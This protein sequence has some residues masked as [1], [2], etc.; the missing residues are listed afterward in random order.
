MFLTGKNYYLLKVIPLPTYKMLMF[1]FVLFSAKVLL[2]QTIFK[3]QK[4]FYPLKWN[5][6]LP[7]KFQIFQMS[8]I[9]SVIIYRCIVCAITYMIWLQLIINF[10]RTVRF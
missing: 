1:E 8:Y 6:C 2:I 4:L 9:L 5:T 3:K 7:Q 10:M